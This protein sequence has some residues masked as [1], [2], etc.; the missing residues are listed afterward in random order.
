[1]CITPNAS[2]DDIPR[3]MDKL[4]CKNTIKKTVTWMNVYHIWAKY[5][6]EVLEIEK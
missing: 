4:K 2:H 5:R 1:M 3:L 6:G